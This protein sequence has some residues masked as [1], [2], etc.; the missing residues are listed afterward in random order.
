MSEVLDRLRRILRRTDRDVAIAGAVV[1]AVAKIAAAVPVTE[2]YSELRLTFRDDKGWQSWTVAPC[3]RQ[4]GVWNEFIKWFHGREQSDYFVMHT[5][6]G[7]NRVPRAEIRHYDI[8]YG[9]RRKP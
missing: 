7:Q 1:G 4:D 5:I 6:T 9:E 2:T 8:T 3:A